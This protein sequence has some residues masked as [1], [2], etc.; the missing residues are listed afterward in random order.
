MWLSNGEV[1]ARMHESTKRKW[2]GALFETD[3]S[4]IRLEEKLVPHSVSPV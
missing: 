2:D 3:R 4:L 1:K